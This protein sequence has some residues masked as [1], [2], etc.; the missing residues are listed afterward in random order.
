MRRLFFLP[1]VL[2][3]FASAVAIGSNDSRALAAKSSIVGTV[4][5]LSSASITVHSVFNVTCKVTHDSP[6]LGGYSVGDRVK[7]GCEHG[8]LAH[9]KH[10]VSTPATS[11]PTA[12]TAANA[13]HATTITPGTTSTA[14]GIGTLSAI[15]TSLG[16]ITVTGDRSLTCT[17]GASSP[18]LAGYHLGDHVKIGCVNGAL[19]VITRADPPPPASTTTTTTASTTTTTPTPTTT[20]ATTTTPASY[21]S[22]TG[23]LTAL[24]S[25][26]IS[27]TGDGMML[28][29]PIGPGAQSLTDFHVGDAVKMYCLNGTFY[30]LIKSTPTTTTTTPAATPPPPTTTTT[31]VTYSSATGTITTLGVDR[32]T[33]TGD[34]VLSCSIAATSPSVTAYHLGD[35]VKMYCQAGALYALI[36]S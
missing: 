9:V 34:A 25:T 6:R 33:V 36:K 4:T 8:I 12:P 32:V 27:A 22:V 20:T 19:Y 30:R 28:T 23:T 10:V 29:C 26:S 35:K 13:E 18:S 1:L 15:S 16:T 11:G 14:S 31:P 2:L 21:T 3:G 5:A 17:I 7:I 24:S